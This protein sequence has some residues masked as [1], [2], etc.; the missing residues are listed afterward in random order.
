MHNH[1]TMK[2]L[3]STTL[4]FLSMSLFAQGDNDHILPESVRSALKILRIDEKEYFANI[5][6]PS[7][8]VIEEDTIVAESEGLA[9]EYLEQGKLYMHACDSVYALYKK[10]PSNF[11]NVT[12]SVYNVFGIIPQEYSEAA[13]L[14]KYKIYAMPQDD[15]DEEELY[16]MEAPEEHRAEYPGGSDAFYKLLTKKIKLPKNELDGVNGTVKV[17]FTVEADGAIANV[18]IARG[19]SPSIDQAIVR[20]VEQMPKFKPA[21]V[22][23]KPVPSQMQFPVRIR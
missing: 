3:L 6:V 9:E 2:I 17:T 1:T 5:Y 22:N 19:L 7:D 23:G 10:N 15:V 11:I 16:L 4:L 8:S 21:T 14:L 18:Q 20:A 13:F 12:P